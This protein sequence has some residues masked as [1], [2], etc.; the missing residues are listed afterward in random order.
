MIKTL[1]FASALAVPFLTLPPLASA[2]PLPDTISGIAFDEG[3]GRPVAQA[4]VTL[5]QVEGGETLARVRTDE[6]GRFSI[7]VGP[8]HFWLQASHAGFASS[9]PREV[10]WERASENLDGLLLNLRTMD[11]EA[12]SVQSEGSVGSEEARV[13]GR[14]TDQNSGNP[15]HGAEVEF[16]VSGLQTTTNR[17]GMFVFPEVP[18]GQ[19]RLRIS[20]LTYG[21]QTRTL[22][23]E[24][25]R[26]YRVRGVVSPDPIELEGI[27]VTATSQN[28]FR[29][30]DGLKWRMDRGTES[31]YVLAEE[32]ETR[33]YPP[34][35]AALRSVPGIR[36]RR[37]GWEWKVVVGRCREVNFWSSQ[38]P[39]VY[40]DGI[41]VYSPRVGTS[42]TM[43]I[44]SDIT[45][46]DIEAIEV[47]HGAASVP[48]EYS[49]SDAQCGAIL[50]WT[51]R[52]VG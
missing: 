31:H 51:K 17:S 39:V 32:L 23:L 11:R 18:P 36:V 24:S 38:S 3:T 49:G 1:C 35:G 26:A 4:I 5:I 22:E 29:R 7:P 16:T 45:S 15:V 20:H 14:I 43:P 50:I 42:G 12:L 52:G 27:R 37:Y 13:F 40:L 44:L 8:G 46:H 48:P 33:G 25:G 41:K 19:E 28:W 2:Q 21:E 30:M 6:A 9:P 34:V 47:Y 10:Y